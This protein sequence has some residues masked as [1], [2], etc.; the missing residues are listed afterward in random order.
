[1]G[2]EKDISM[3]P[4]APKN[5]KGGGFADGLP[6]G[7]DREGGPR[8]TQDD[9]QMVLEKQMDCDKSPAGER[10]GGRSGVRERVSLSQHGPATGRAPAPPS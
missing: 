5:V 4:R 6:T 10:G 7:D 1:M 8:V 2:G 3:N 9:S